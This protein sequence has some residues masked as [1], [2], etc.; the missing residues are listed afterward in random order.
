VPYLLEEAYEAAA[1]LADGALEEMREELGDVL[2]QVLLHAQIEAESGRFGIG[3]VA[4]A[5]RE[6]LVRRHPHVFGE[7]QAGTADEVRLRWEEIKGHEARSSEDRPQPALL[8]AAKLVEIRKAQG[9]PIPTGVHLR[10][11]P[12]GP[13]PERVVGEILL[14]AVAVARDLGCDP[15]LALHRFLSQEKGR[16]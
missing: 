10:L 12:N 16:G 14:E 15:E 11:P 9:D 3:E 5:L 7:G 13:D 2:L 1:A 6:K 4:D 8:A